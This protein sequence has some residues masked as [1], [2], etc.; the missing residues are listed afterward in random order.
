LQ[1][2]ASFCRDCIEIGNT[3]VTGNTGGG[4]VTFRQDVR[5]A[6]RNRVMIY[7]ILRLIA[8]D[9]TP[10]ANNNPIGF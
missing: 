9:R 8:D 4:I 5:N 1:L 2:T 3:G 7:E 10:R 6:V